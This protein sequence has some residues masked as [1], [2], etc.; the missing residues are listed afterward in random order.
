VVVA[1][2]TPAAVEQ[3]VGFGIAEHVFEVLR[4]M[5]RGTG[6]F[7]GSNTGGGGRGG[8]GGGVGCGGGGGGGGGGDGLSGNV[9]DAVVC[10]AL[11]SLTYM[12]WG[13]PRAFRSRLVLGIEP[14]NAVFA[15]AVSSRD[16]TVG[17]ETETKHQQEY[18]L[19]L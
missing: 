7:E 2:Q 19:F 6:G 16:A 4:D 5:N 12:A 9:R 14:L 15:D 17:N 8:G 3:L 18:A 13:A 11:D 1:G 10:A